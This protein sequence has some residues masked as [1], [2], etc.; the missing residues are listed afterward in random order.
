MAT[1]RIA[2]RPVDEMDTLI[3]CVRMRY[4][5]FRSLHYFMLESALTFRYNVKYYR[6]SIQVYPLNKRGCA[7]VLFRIVYWR[8][9]LNELAGVMVH[10]QGRW[11][12]WTMEK[13][14]L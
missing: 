8:V 14:G 12:M 5:V 10:H 11:T 3:L 1:C 6:F 2:D 7:S 9:R 4:P 13:G